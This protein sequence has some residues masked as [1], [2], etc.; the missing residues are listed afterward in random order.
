MHMHT[1][2]HRWE[3]AP[4]NVTPSLAGNAWPPASTCSS[5]STTCW[6]SFRQVAWGTCFCLKQFDNVLVFLQASDMRPMPKTC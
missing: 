4:R 5:S 2:K 6:C 1:C 3:P